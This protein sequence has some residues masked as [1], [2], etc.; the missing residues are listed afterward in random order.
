M[1]L[2]MGDRVDSRDVM[3]ANAQTKRAFAAKVLGHFRRTGANPW[4]PYE[5]LDDPGDAIEVAPGIPVQIERSTAEVRLR[6]HGEVYR[7]RWEPDAEAAAVLR[8]AGPEAIRAYFVEHFLHTQE[9]PPGM[10]A[11]AVIASKLSG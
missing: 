7:V 11:A 10:G 1:L 9:S 6:R 5:W 3:D 4:D 8:D 2:A